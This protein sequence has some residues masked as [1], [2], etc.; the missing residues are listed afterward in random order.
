MLVSA[1]WII[2]VD[3]VGS[4]VFNATLAA[5]EP[6]RSSSKKAAVGGSV[7][8]KWMCVRKCGKNKYVYWMCVYF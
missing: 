4:L 7:F 3:N 5:G 2:A 8:W 6:M 1:L